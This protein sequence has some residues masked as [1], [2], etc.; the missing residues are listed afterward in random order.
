MSRR[1]GS[2][3]PRT[4]T[5]SVAARIDQL[6]LHQRRVDAGRPEKGLEQ[7]VHVSVQQH[8]ELRACA[9]Q[10][11][12]VDGGAAL[13]EAALEASKWARHDPEIQ[14]L[15]GAEVVV[16]GREVVPERSAISRTVARR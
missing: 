8:D 3:E 14:A 15:L 1:I 10:G 7:G 9:A 2:I 6:A 16:G 5:G 12:R 11:L 4:I 13:G